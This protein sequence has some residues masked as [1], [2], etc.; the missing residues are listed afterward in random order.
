MSELQDRYQRL[1]RCYVEAL[2]NRERLHGRIVLRFSVAP[3]GA[4]QQLRVAENTTDFDAFGCCV[5]AVVRE[6][7]WPPRAATAPVGLEYPFV[8]HLVRMPIGHR[9]DLGSDFVYLAVQPNGYELALDG[10]MYGGGPVR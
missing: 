7:A 1:T 6:I 5:A 9:S 3:G 2:A 8:F 4:V 10:A